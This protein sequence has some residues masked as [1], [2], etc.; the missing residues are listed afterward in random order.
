MPNVLMIGVV[1]WA[2]LIMVAAWVTVMQWRRSGGQ[3]SMPVRDRRAVV[4]GLADAGTVRRLPGHHPE[5]VRQG[6]RS[7]VS[8]EPGPAAESQVSGVADAEPG[9]HRPGAEP[10]QRQAGAEVITASERIARFYQEADR[11]V[12][13]L[14]TALGWTQERRTQDPG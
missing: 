1:L 8:A 12:A 13:D 4:A 3:P 14:L 10:D 11:P 7:D 5:T 9:S 6:R 2:G